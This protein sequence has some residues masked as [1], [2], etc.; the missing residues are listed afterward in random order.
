MKTFITLII[1]IALFGLIFETSAQE[2][3]GGTPYSLMFQIEDSPT[4]E[5]DKPEMK[6]I[7]EEDLINDNL[8]RPSPRRMGI[9]VAANI[10]L[11]ESGKWTTIEGV[12]RI[13]CLE[14]TVQDAL[15]LGVYYTDFFIPEGGE[16]FLYNES[17]DQIIGSFTRENN[18]SEKLFATEFIQGDRV[19][20]E[21]F[22]PLT[23]SEKARVTISEL[24]YAYRDI[25]YR[26]DRNRASW[27]CMI[28]V[29]C[30][31]GDN[32]ENQIKGVARISIR[33]GGSYYWC[34][35]SLI[36][37][38]SNDRTP[39]FLTAAHCGHGASTSDLNQWIFYFNYQADNCQ[40]NNSGSNSKTGCSL[41]ARDMSVE[42]E[43]GSDFFL[44]EFNSDISDSYDV[45]YNGWN[46]TN[47]NE[48]AQSGVGIHHPAGDIKKI[49]TYDTP[50]MSSTWWNGLPSHWRLNWAETANG[51]SIMQGGSSGS[52]IFDANGFIMGDLTGGYA[53]NSCDN[54]SP[55][56]YGKIWYSWDQN[57]TTNATQLKP[58]LDADETGI[59][60]LPGVS[61]EIIPPE[62]DF[63][64]F[65]SNI[66][67]GD[68]VLFLDQSGPGI[69]EWEWLFEGGD[70]DTS[71]T[72]DPYIVYADTGYFD[73]S[74]HVINADGEDTE[75]REDYIY[76]NAMLAPVVDFIADDTTVPERASVHFTDLSENNP[77]EW[78]WEFDG[79]SPATSSAQNPTVRYNNTGVYNVTLIASNLG[80]SDTLIKENYI[81]VGGVLPGADFEADKSHITQGETV[82]F[83]D[84]SSGEPT[85]WAWSF[86]GG[87]PDT[88]NL[89][90]PSDI[91]YN[92]GG[93][94][95]V[96]L[97]VENGVGQSTLTID[98]YILV[99]W[100]GL[101]EFNGP[102][103]F[104]IYPNP[105]TGIFVVEFAEAGNQPVSV[106]ISNAAGQIIEETD[107]I[108]SKHTFVIDIQNQKKGLYFVVIDD[109]EN[110][111][112]KKLSLTK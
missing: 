90:D 51:R 64:T 27:W 85:S 43:D 108:K 36:N 58:W 102:N 95:T 87:T 28:N 8:D 88:S 105:G 49:S 77:T 3:R 60:K 67:Q 12:G 86:E 19:I 30:E 104:R 56:W 7:W 37:N 70:P 48:D 68:T 47:S 4:L 66:T 92:E 61:W 65:A 75:L 72:Q 18:P 45:F 57:G 39:Y 99:D 111:V 62:A 110:Q 76:I 109:G 38:T 35:G 78:Y 107:L 13:C 112:V 41:L 21:Y 103:D 91:I 11:L 14:I 100:V 2:S 40:G 74:L 9:S 101:E 97:T 16:L 83:T 54:P 42:A 6:P 82:N 59:E 26:F 15:A 89:Q 17:K 50:L 34:S 94:F 1:G 106:R 5:L 31:E 20:L 25:A 55:A 10:D 24:A 63:M 79:G 71:S 80:G 93:A 23:V 32:W 98:D 29:A 22:E 46:R 73:V 44:V 81:I 53:S 96:S 69:M 33:I 84:L 52:P